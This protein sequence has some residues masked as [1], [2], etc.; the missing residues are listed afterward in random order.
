MAI[1]EVESG[2]QT[3]TT[4]HT[5][6]SGSATD[7]VYVCKFNLD[8]MVDGDVLKVG[9]RGGTLSGDADTDEYSGYY[10]H[11]D[12]GLSDP[13]VTTPPVVIVQGTARCY[14]E[15]IGSNSVSV[16]WALIRIQ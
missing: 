3:A 14:V 13:N 16:P 2:T 6:G 12:G 15:E 10:Q 11:A 8:D 7:G 9:I 5:L 4:T 1:T